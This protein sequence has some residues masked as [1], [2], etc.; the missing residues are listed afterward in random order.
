M[1]VSLYVKHGVLRVAQSLLTG[2]ANICMWTLGGE[3]CETFVGFPKRFDCCVQRFW[4]SSVV[5]KRRGM[6]SGEAANGK[7]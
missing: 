4:P 1:M 2:P 5:M 6:Q 3:C 7:P